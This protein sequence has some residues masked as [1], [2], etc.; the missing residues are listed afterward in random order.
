MQKDKIAKTA[1]YLAGAFSLVC[2]L[3]IRIPALFNALVFEKVIPE[4]WENTKYGELYNF[5]RID[6]FKEDLPP[7]GIKY[8]YTD[9]HPSVNEADLLTFGDSFFDFARLI[10]VPEKLGDTLGKRVFYARYDQPLNYLAEN[11]YEAGDSKILLYETTERYIPFRFSEPHQ[12]T[13]IPD[14]RSAFRLK[15]AAIRDFIFLKDDEV[16]YSLLLSRSYA[17][18][19]LYAQVAT[20]KFNAFGYIA[21][22]TPVYSLKP[23]TPWLFYFEEVNDENTSFYYN[24]SNADIEN[25]CNNIADLRVKLKQYYNLDMVFLPAPS[26]FTIYST[27]VDTIPYNNLL[28]RIYSG[29]EKRGVP[30]IDLYDDFIQSADTLYYAT[31]THWN[32]KGLQL[33][34]D[35]TTGFLNRLC[36]VQITEL[37]TTDYRQNQ[38]N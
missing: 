29:L 30:V 24:H 3:A 1:V 33:V 12:L 16:R 13:Y 9:K 2:F 37:D 10:T 6:H 11:G 22:T 7:A 26:K 14:T 20:L 31:D 19:G 34:V 15:L 8:R 5:N 18:A 28:P 17:T 4:Y 36:P 35:K 38:I 27:L 25:Y 21:S 32:E 23:K